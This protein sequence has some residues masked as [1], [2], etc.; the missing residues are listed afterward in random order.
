MRMRRLLAAVVLGGVLAT[1]VGQPAPAR[2]G[3]TTDAAIIAGAALGGIL[4]FVIVGTLITR[5]SPALLVPVEGNDDPL[6]GRDTRV[7]WGLACART[8]AH[9]LAVCW[10]SP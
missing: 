5:S 6:Q 3:S 8:G 7:R 2:A 9:P 4:A 1:G 10:Q